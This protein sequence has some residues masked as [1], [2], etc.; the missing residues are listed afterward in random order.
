MA[1]LGVVLGGIIGLWLG[2][3]GR[4]PLAMVLGAMLGWLWARV[5]GLRRR[6][7]ELEAEAHARRGAVP[8]VAPMAVAQRETIAEA[9]SRLS[10]DL[11]PAMAS[12]WN[13][14]EPEP[15][16]VRGP[17]REPEPEPVSRP[18]PAAFTPVEPMPPNA[19][20]RALS[21]L[22]AWLF[23][24]NVP[25]K[26]GMLVL[27]FG[28]AAGLKYSVDAGWIKVSMAGRMAGMA[29]L[30]LTAIVWGWR[31]RQA[32]PAFGLSM[33]GGGIGIVLLTVFAAYRL[34]H[35]LPATLA[36]ALVL[37]M[38]AGAAALAVLQDALALAVLGFLGGYLAPVLL[39]TGSGNHVALF[40][41]YALLNLA[42]FFIAWFRHW[43]ALNLIGFFF[44]FAVGLAW[45]AQYYE[46]QHLPTVEPFLITF[47]LFYV[48][49]AVLHALRAPE[50]RR[51]FVDGTLVFGTPLLAFPLQAAMLYPTPMALAFSALAV[52]VMYAGLA[53]WLM[54]DRRHWLL[55]QSFGVLA[56]GFATLAV[57][58]A[59]SARATGI[60]WAL[61]GAALVWLGLRQNRRLPQWTGIALHVAAAAA[62]VWNQLEHDAW[63]AAPGEWLILNAHAFSTVVLAATAFAISAL[64]ERAGKNRFWVWPGFLLGLFWW[65]LAGAREVD[66]IAGPWLAGEL[67]GYSVS[68]WV[69]FFA[70]SLGLMAATR[71]WVPWPRVGWAVFV[72][73]AGS[74]L[75]ATES[76]STLHS[77]LH[78]PSAGFW[79][80][81][82]VA[83]CAA[84]ASLRQPQQRFL[85]LAHVLFLACLSLVY[86]LALQRLSRDSGLGADWSYFA[87]FTPL[88][89]LVILTWRWPAVGTWPLGREFPAYAKGWFV[90]AG[91]VLALASVQSLLLSGD[92]APLPY[93]P[94]LNPTELAPLLGVLALVRAIGPAQAGRWAPYLAIAGFVWLSFTGLRAVHHFAHLPWDDSLLSYGVAQTTLTVLWAVAGVTAWIL[95][96]RS[97]RWP[98]WLSGAILMGVVL[99]KL[100]LIDR[101]HMGNLAGI[102]SFMAVGGLLVLVGRIAPT[103]PRQISPAS[104]EST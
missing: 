96:S 38:V 63:D 77:P 13:A 19:V 40:S 55:A 17:E 51:G 80:V 3:L 64:F 12:A 11:K 90:P 35:L 78:W 21:R 60:T 28:V 29:A 8:A 69:A 95:G 26:I 42:V 93:V 1:W 2:E 37:V 20:E 72:L 44:T 53:F 4:E 102:V 5:S 23:E 103:P 39:S 61:E 62:W 88:V 41:F 82:V 18:E 75:S 83:G 27:L 16:P 71:R 33:Q 89:L 66:E 47:F 76:G 34:Y 68:A 91:I 92:T 9:E 58:L 43:R 100:V 10:D 65:F 59:F 67:Y 6:V 31:N 70:L 97:Q 22:W 7:V 25:V 15:M 30:G 45:G 86:G 87:T 56:V 54:R 24:G 57:P 101:G 48:A 52:A 32:R 50:A 81:W 99:L 84:L 49:I 46:P 94:L 98:L 73:L 79:W 104:G 85:G 36:F 14:V 74:L